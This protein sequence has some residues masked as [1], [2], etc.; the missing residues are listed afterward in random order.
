[1]ISFTCS[2]GSTCFGDISNKI[3]KAVTSYI[4]NEIDKHTEKLKNYTPLVN[5]FFLLECV[6]YSS[7]R[8]EKIS[9]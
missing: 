3:K 2:V 5:H 6:F 1:M 7:E 4:I 8:G 9:H